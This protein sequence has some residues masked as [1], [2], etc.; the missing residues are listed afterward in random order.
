M[1]HAF[2]CLAVRNYRIWAAGALVSNVG[3]WVQ[4]VA[5]NWLV[6]TELTRNSATAVG[7]VMALQF[8]PHFLLLPFTGHAADHCNRRRLLFATQASMGLLALGLGVL[9]VTGHTRLWHVYVFA[10]LLGCVT[11][12]DSP[13]RQVFVAELVGD[14]ELPNAVAL[15]STSF[16]AARMVGPAV[17]GAVIAAAGTGW[18]FVLN[19]LSFAAVLLSLAL[20]DGDQLHGAAAHAGRGPRRGGPLDGLRYVWARA[21]LRVIVVML[22]L[23]GTF[24]LNF[25]IFISTMAVTVFHVGAGRYGLLTSVMAVGTLVGSLLAARRQAPGMAQLLNGATVFGVGCALAALAPS[26]ALFGLA[27]AIIGASA[28][29]FTT[30]T[31]SLMQ[32]STEPAMRGRVMAIRL[33]VAMGTTPVGAPLV[34]WVADRWGAR[35]ALGVAA[36]A[37]ASAALVALRYRSRYGDRPGSSGPQSLGR[38]AAA[39]NPPGTRSAARGHQRQSASGGV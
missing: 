36:A 29:T 35:W 20:L 30:T 27:L 7:V 15:N 18:A 24:G 26:Y 3:T 2:R 23:I 13:A 5:Q 19:A 22:F 39:P 33:A 17:A 11:A 12:F 32:L 21:D 4:R 9:T 6:L 38:S 8:G 37:G 16:N 10:L 25:Q 14:A 31:N 34:G 28:L 1:R